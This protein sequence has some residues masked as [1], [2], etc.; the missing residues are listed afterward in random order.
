MCY[1]KHNYSN[2]AFLKRSGK[3]T[4]EAQKHVLIRS[5]KTGG[6]IVTLLHEEVLCMSG[7]HPY[8]REYFKLLNYLDIA[9]V[10]MLPV[11]EA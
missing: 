8:K 5:R 6:R 3:T 4:S 7:N 2:Q 1:F 9:A 10:R 11:Y